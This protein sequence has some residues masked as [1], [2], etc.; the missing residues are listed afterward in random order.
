MARMK[1]YTLPSLIIFAL[2]A[3]FLL[4]CPV[5]DQP[6]APEPASESAPE[7]AP[8]PASETAPEPAPETAPEPT[9]EPA[10]EP[11][12]V[13]FDFDDTLVFSSPAFKEGFAGKP[14]PYSKGFWEIV[15]AS[16]EG[17]SVVKKKT[18][19]ILEKH[20]ARGDSIYVITAR[21]P[22]GGDKVK[23]YIQKTFAIPPGN[24]FFETRGKERRIRALGLSIFY[25]DSDSDIKA[26]QKAGIIGVRILRSP[27]S[28][29][30]GKNNPGRFNEE[31]VPGSQ[32]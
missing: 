12:A 14:K 25:G 23:A 28:S 20:R 5:K 11:V 30:K 16:D 31:I 18:L 21:K 6:P 9:P 19:E 4:G 1:R 10:P 3:L 27:N 8:E 7:P 22:Y 26:A 24:V 2:F 29:Y 15:N 13:G 17:R 32:E